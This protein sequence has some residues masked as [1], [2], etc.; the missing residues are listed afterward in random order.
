VGK[1]TPL[2]SEAL[3]YELPNGS[4]GYATMAA[5]PLLDEGT[6]LGAVI[7]F[8][9]TT[10]ATLLAAELAATRQGGGGHNTNGRRT[11]R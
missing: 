8:E 9:D 7:V 1:S 5:V 2:R 4:Q 3:T 10:K 11:R 6:A